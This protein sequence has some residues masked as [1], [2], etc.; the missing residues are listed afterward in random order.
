MNISS[1]AFVRLIAFLL[2]LLYIILFMEFL[3]LKHSKET[4]R[5]IL[6]FGFQI[7]F[8]LIMV[9][10]LVL[11]ERFSSAYLSRHVF[12]FKHNQYGWAS[13]FF[14]VITADILSNEK[15]SNTYKI[16]CATLIPVGFFTLLACGNRATW[17]ST[18]ISLILWIFVWKPYCFPK[19]LKLA[20]PAILF[21]GAIVFTFLPENSFR[22]AFERT[23]GQLKYGTAT[24]ERLL[25]AQSALNDFLTHP[26][27]WFLGRGIFNY[28]GLINENGYHN[29][30]YEILFGCGIPLFILFLYLFFLKPFYNFHKYYSHRLLTFWPLVIIP[31]FESNLTGGQFLFYPWFSIMMFYAFPV[32]E[33]EQKSLQ[34]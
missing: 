13:I 10:Y 18:L 32:T 25:W 28:K 26:W 8:G 5:K 3:F 27:Q 31:F 4:I 16:I 34:I 22:L 7:I 20:I 15:C 21:L 14:L 30:Y 33:E 19:K 9:A 12:L 11:E 6:W 24:S 29:S 1:N 17:L 23:Y 2:P